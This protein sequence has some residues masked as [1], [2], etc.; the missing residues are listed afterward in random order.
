MTLLRPGNINENTVFG[1]AC[2]A[3]TSD[4]LINSQRLD[5]AA[6]RT[7]PQFSPHRLPNRKR[8]FS[9]FSARLLGTLPSGW[10]IRCGAL[11]WY[12]ACHVLILSGPK[13]SSDEDH[14]TGALR[15]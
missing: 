11:A 1:S 15:R 10:G 9:A 2:W 4:P 5:L 7:N 12:L 8:P 6:G 3:R 13:Q 14:P